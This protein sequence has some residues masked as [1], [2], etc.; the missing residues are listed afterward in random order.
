MSSKETMVEETKSHSQAKREERKKEVAAAKRNAVTLKIVG[1]VVLA[2]FVGLIAWGISGLVMKQMDKVQQSDDYSAG[3]EANG[4][5]TGVNASEVVTLP[6]Y[7]GIEVPY[8]EIE[9][10][11]ES[12]DSDIE[13]LLGGYTYASDDASLKVADGDKVSIAY[14]GKINGE[15]FDG[16]KSDSYDLTIGSNQLIKGFEEQLIGAANG[17]TVT[18]NVTFPDDYA[19]TELAGKDAVFTVDIKGIYVEPEFTDEFVAENLSDEATTVEGYRAH[20]RD[21]KEA[22]NIKEWVTTYLKDNSTV[23]KYPN[24]YVKILKSIQKY[25]DM[26]SYQYMNQMYQQYLGYNYYSSFEDY[27]GMT[28]AEYDVSLKDTCKETAKENMIYQAIIEKEGAVADADY[29]KGYLETQGNDATYYDSQVATAGEPFVL[30]QAIKQKALEIVT[31]AV[32]V[33]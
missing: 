22:E 23:S 18:V 29:Y 21:E 30:Q 11:D 13:S 27:V 6:E 4:Y 8:S 1:Y 17:T 14:L 16:G 3:L 2:I 25:D 31:G 24:K 12:I 15:E 9:Y 7:K 26:E 28:E 32:V 19:K 20:I 33:K 5:I 10:T